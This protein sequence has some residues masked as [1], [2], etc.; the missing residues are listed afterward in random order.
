VQ[1]TAAHGPLDFD[2]SLGPSDRARFNL[3]GGFG[4]AHPSFYRLGLRWFHYVEFANFGGS[5][6]HGAGPDDGF[7]YRRVGDIRPVALVWPH[8]TYS[9]TG[10]NSRQRA[11]FL[12]RAAHETGSPP[13]I[14]RGTKGHT[15]NL[16]SFLL[17][18]PVV[19]V[20]LSLTVA[21]AVEP[22]VL[23]PVLA[24]LAVWAELLASLR[25]FR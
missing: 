11:V 15:V 6:G 8:A 1:S 10:S 18:M 19:I 22:R 5:E 25:L 4:V 2:R 3:N 9:N 17:L 16:Y 21:A 13:P 20:F 7:V 24:L 14:A 12:G 23:R